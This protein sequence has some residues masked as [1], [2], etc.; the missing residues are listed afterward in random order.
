MQNWS[1]VKVCGM[2]CIPSAGLHWSELWYSARCPLNPPGWFCWWFCDRVPHLPL[3]LSAYGR[4]RHKIK[5]TVFYCLGFILFLLP[6]QK[7]ATLSSPQNKLAFY[8][9]KMC[10]LSL[11][12][13][14]S[15]C[16]DQSED[17]VRPWAFVIHACSCSSSLFISKLKPGL[18]QFMG[19][20]TGTFHYIPYFTFL[21]K[22]SRE[23]ASEKWPEIKKAGKKE[24]RQGIRQAC[25]QESEQERRHKAQKRG[26]KQESK[27]EGKKKH[28][29]WK[30]ESKQER[31]SILLDVN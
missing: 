20:Y 30:K 16:H 10:R 19:E 1:V 13:N 6:S 14:L 3:V 21:K 9:I 22:E 4:R 17:G 25:K 29:A 27:K 18:K 2:R 23:H 12:T 31:K 26:S 28:K 15:L 24:R 5:W 11:K 7:W 8:F